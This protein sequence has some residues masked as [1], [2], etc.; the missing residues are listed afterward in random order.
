[1]NS[2]SSKKTIYCGKWLHL[3]T[4]NTLNSQGVSFSD[5]EC[6]SRTSK[7]EGLYDALSIVAILKNKETNR[8]QLIL[9]AEYRPPV[10]KFVLELPAGLAESETALE[11]ISR[12]MREETGYVI[13]KTQKTQKIRESPLITAE[14]K[15]LEIVAKIFT[16]EIDADDAE[17]KNPQQRLEEE[18]NIR[19]HLV[20]L[21]ENFMKNI[22]ELAQKNQYF[23]HDK[24][25]F[26][27]KGLCEN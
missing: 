2:S 22:E 19:V 12:E 27:A 8:K 7:K 11:D 21:D 14:P 16:L 1:M 6:L 18:E 9:I 17:N 26:I 23:I 15:L 5:Y 10:A 20:D 4:L 25:F 3:Y 13:E 24:L